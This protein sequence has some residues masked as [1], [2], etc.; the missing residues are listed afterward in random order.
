MLTVDE[1]LK[2]KG[3]AFPAPDLPYDAI[4][5]HAYTL[6]GVPMLVSCYRCGTS[7]ACHEKLACDE[8]GRIFCDGCAE[9]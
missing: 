9:G 5:E 2:S 1:Y 6:A 4:S 7:M 8:N 3:K